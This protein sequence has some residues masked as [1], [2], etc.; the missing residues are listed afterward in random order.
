MFT[1]VENDLLESLTTDIGVLQIKLEVF[2]A[3]ECI[4]SINKL[5]NDLIRLNFHFSKRKL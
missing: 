3:F 5:C 1:G 4:K 2:Q